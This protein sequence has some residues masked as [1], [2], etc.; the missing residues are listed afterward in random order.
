MIIVR[1]NFSELWKQLKGENRKETLQHSSQFSRLPRT[2]SHDDS[3]VI[4]EKFLEK[5]SDLRSSVAK[6][7]KT[8]KKVQ[9][10]PG[11]SACEE[12]VARLEK[13]VSK[14]A[15]ANQN[16]EDSDSTVEIVSSDDECDEASTP[17]SSNSHSV[18][19]TAHHLPF[20]ECNI[21]DYVIISYEGELYPG[22][23]KTRTTDGCEVSVME[24]SGCQLG[25]L[26]DVNTI[27]VPTQL[28]IFTTKKVV[29]VA[30]GQSHS[31]I[32]LKY[33]EVYS[34][35]DN[36][37]GQL[38]LRN[39]RPVTE[40]TIID[41]FEGLPVILL[42]AGGWHSFCV[43]I[44]GRVFSWGKNDHGQLG[45]GDFVGHASPKLMKLSTEDPVAY[46]SA[47]DNHS[48]ILTRKGE[49]LT[50]G[51]NSSGQLG[52]GD[53]NNISVSKQVEE[54]KGSIVTQI[55]CGHNHTVAFVPGCGQVFTFGNCEYGQLGLGKLVEKV[56]TPEIVKKTWFPSP[57]KDGNNGVK[58]CSGGN[59][60]YVMFDSRCHMPSDYRV[61]DDQS[62]IA[63]FDKIFCESNN[64]KAK[65]DDLFHAMIASSSC[66]NGSFPDKDEVT[67]IDY[68]GINLEHAKQVFTQINDCKIKKASIECLSQMINHLVKEPPDL[69]AL[70]LYITLPMF[71]N[72]IE[73]I[74]LANKL[75]TLLVNKILC[76]SGNLWKLLKKWYRSSELAFVTI[77]KSC[78]RIIS[79]AWSIKSKISISPEC[80]NGYLNILDQLYKLNELHA[81]SSY[82]VFYLSLILDEK[83]FL[84]LFLQ[85]KLG[86][87][88]LLFIEY[89]FIV[90][91]KVKAKLL[92][93][94]ADFRKKAAQVQSV[95]EVAT[96]FRLGSSKPP[97]I[98]ISVARTSLVSDS[99]KQFANIDDLQRP[100]HVQFKGED[101]IDDG[102]LSKEYFFYIIPELITG[103]GL[104]TE[105][106]VS[107]FVWF[108]GNYDDHKEP[109]YNLA[110]KL[111]GL[112]LFNST[113]V[114]VNF[115]L[116]LYKK[117]L[118]IEP[119]FEDL[120]ELDPVFGNSLQQILEYEEEDGETVQEVFMASFV[121]FDGIPLK[122]GGEEIPVTSANREEYVKLHMDYILNK[123]VERQFR[124]FQRG[125]SKACSGKIFDIFRPEELMEMVVGEQDFSWEEVKAS[126]NVSLLSDEFS[127]VC[128]W[129]WEVLLSFEDEE[130]EQFLIFLTASNKVPVSG[131]EF[132]IQRIEA[133]DK[134]L[135]I[136]M[137]CYNIL[138]LPVYSSKEVLED[139][140]KLAIQCKG[141]HLK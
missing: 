85:W 78:T 107:N 1:K 60:T 138:Q 83:L 61:V 11:K 50:F 64:T 77:V 26:K 111:C 130:K 66:W 54:F 45:V 113:V 21:G 106:E 128:E 67:S 10:E 132:K 141:F 119:V 36:K 80:I 31:L 79:H 34:V 94:D 58:I 103:Y 40:P 93:M 51:L 63:T 16:I 35:G 137:T 20:E 32:L 131:F 133:N 118:G 101:G 110:G 88:S 49:M 70:R 39:K 81:M 7:T 95:M 140:L 124:A 96:S 47:G 5:I 74:E 18:V 56:L 27:Q 112:A 122:K 115:P 135:P 102:A 44:S 129:F 100:L 12:D 8:R 3:D 2:T 126:M 136:A 120:K 90:D 48:A 127:E 17:E 29:H 15:Q 82:K 69:D 42:A 41:S 108:S 22:I 37:H 28:D 75:L 86:F 89:P 84:D 62:T 14:K 24:K 13:T 68:H 57:L 23:V 99:V 123:S 43:T 139:R 38:G 121:S 30:C 104:F 19:S 65:D 52:H 59:Q 72:T 105:K 46:I 109:L 55:A 4:S 76:L 134:V 71:I 92:I 53:S 73:N 117:L 125:F 91:A 116:V 114:N 97:K 25:L 6:E 87:V 9:V 33:G 98:K